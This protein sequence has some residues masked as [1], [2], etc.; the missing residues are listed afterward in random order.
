[1][2]YFNDTYDEC[3]VPITKPISKEQFMSEIKAASNGCAYFSTGEEYSGFGIGES[4]DDNDHGF[5]VG[6]Y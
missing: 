5:V 2:T 6:E 4:D 1:M 3:I